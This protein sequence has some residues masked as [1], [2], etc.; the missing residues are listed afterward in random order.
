M[1]RLNNQIYRSFERAKSWV[2]VTQE[3]MPTAQADR[4][5]FTWAHLDLDTAKKMGHLQD[6]PLKNPSEFMD[7]TNVHL[8]LTSP[9]IQAARKNEKLE[10]GIKIIITYY[11]LY[12]IM[13]YHYIVLYY[14][15][16]YI[17]YIYYIILYYIILLML[18]CLWLLCLHYNIIINYY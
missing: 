4:Q 10:W 2:H 18:I 7:W 8:C 17:Y 3:W 12:Y 9:P 14:S 11:I 1:K 6:K 13:L 15:I 16:Y 5:P